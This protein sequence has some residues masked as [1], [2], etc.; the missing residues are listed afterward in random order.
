MVVPEL[1][2]NFAAWN[3]EKRELP[4][5]YEKDY[6]HRIVLSHGHSSLGTRGQAQDNIFDRCR[7][8]AGEAEQ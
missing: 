6:I 8:Y 5:S 3:K 1:L 2:T 4:Y 7:A